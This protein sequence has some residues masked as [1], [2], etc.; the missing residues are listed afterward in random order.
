MSPRLGPNASGVASRTDGGGW[1]TH[2]PHMR[3]SG[4]SSIGFCE[5]GP[6]PVMSKAGDCLREP[7]GNCALE[8]WIR[9]VLVSPA[10]RSLTRNGFFPD[11]LLSGLASVGCIEIGAVKVPAAACGS[12]PCL[13]MGLDAHDGDILIALFEQSL[14]SPFSAGTDRPSSSKA[15]AIRSMLS[16]SRT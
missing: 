14:L 7:A 1:S 2:G 12:W 9:G 4:E 10:V 16:G 5:L 11:C 8:L 15:L 3:F 13:S 6:R